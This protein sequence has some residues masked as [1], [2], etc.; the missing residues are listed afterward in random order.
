MDNT[1]HNILNSFFIKIAVIAMSLCYVFGPS[2]YVVSQLLHTISHSIEASTLFSGHH[3][4][5]HHH[6][7]HHIRTGHAVTETHSHEIL[8]VIDSVL[9]SS[10]SESDSKKSEIVTFKLDKHLETNKYYQIQNL[11]W[12]LK[13]QSA[14]NFNKQKVRK[15]YING[16]IEPPQY[17]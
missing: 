9:E 4:H 10:N 3:S 11:D 16:L 14:F 12:S 8:E 7:H 2:H 5:E 13:G 15:G 6:D 1:T 17:V